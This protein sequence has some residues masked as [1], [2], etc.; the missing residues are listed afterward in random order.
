M[1]YE[2]GK[3][4]IPRHFMFLSLPPYETFELSDFCQSFFRIWRLVSSSR[5]TNTITQGAEDGPS[6]H[7][8]Y[9]VLCQE[10]IDRSFCTGLA[11]IAAHAVCA[12]PL[13]LGGQVH[14]RHSHPLHISQMSCERAPTHIPQPSR[15]CHESSAL[16]GVVAFHPTPPQEAG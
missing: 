8:S 9:Q 1:H 7:H 5:S 2:A 16:R 4:L 15:H 3:P 6:Q 12:L 14:H 10:G 11:H 13:T